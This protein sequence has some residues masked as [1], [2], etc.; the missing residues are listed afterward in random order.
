MLRA[1]Y[2]VAL[3]APEF[4]LVRVHVHELEAAGQLVRQHATAS[5]LGGEGAAIGTA[6][7]IPQPPLELDADSASGTAQSHE[8]DRLIKLHI[9]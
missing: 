9:H 1:R 3:Q 4:G 2:D 7:R 5:A 6:D 8:Q